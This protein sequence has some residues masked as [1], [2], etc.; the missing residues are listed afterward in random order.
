MFNFGIETVI[1]LKFGWDIFMNCGC[2]MGMDDRY[3]DTPYF[4]VGQHEHKLETY[5]MEIS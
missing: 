2:I 1:R 5:D 4:V 3:K